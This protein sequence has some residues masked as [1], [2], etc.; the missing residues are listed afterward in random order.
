MTRGP[1][2]LRGEHA[3]GGRQAPK[4]TFGVHKDGVVRFIAKRSM[5][6]GRIPADI[7]HRRQNAQ[8]LR[9]DG[10]VIR[11]RTKKDTRRDI[12]T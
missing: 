11:D 3:S 10:W 8:K 4:G 9:G 5:N 6:C 7:F 2:Q 12:T 1:P